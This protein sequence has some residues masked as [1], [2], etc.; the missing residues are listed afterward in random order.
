MK[1][2][3]QH[4]E[5]AKLFLEFN[6]S[7]AIYAEMGLGKTAIVLSY[8]ADHMR[9]GE[10][11]DVLVVCPASLVPNWEQAI[12]E[13]ADFE[14]ITEDDLN[15]LRKITIRSYQKM[16][17]SSKVD[18]PHRDGRVTKKRSL[19]LREDV[20]RKWDLFV[21]DESHS[22]GT[23]NSIQTKSAISLSK[24]SDRIILLSGTPFHGPGGRPAYAKMYGQFQVLS[25]G[26]LWRSWTQFCEEYVTSYDLWHNP[27][28]FN[29]EKCRA[30]I[31]DHSIT[32]R[33]ADCVD[34][35]ERVEQTI[36]CPL[37]ETKMYEDI[38]KGDVSKYGIDIESG[39][40]FYLKMLQICSGSMKRPTDT[41][42]L[43]TSKDDVLADILN[44]TDDKVVVFCNYRASVDRCAQI[45]RKAG[46]KTIT[47]DGR[48]ASDAWKQFTEGDCTAIVCQYQSGGVGLNL[49]CSHTMVLFEPCLSAL[50]LEQAKGRIYRK[51]Q[52]NRCVYYY[53]TTPKSIE[54]RVADSVRKG[55][56]VSNEM[57]ERFALEV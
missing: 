39:G 48:S 45:C 42:M 28:S 37:A 8:V 7:L 26:K 1:R 4:Q 22:I 14:G 44:G 13:M 47:Y 24:L 20:D 16:Y 55:V 34:M 46:R 6:P 29:E 23:H 54:S 32:Y 41:M 53:L 52:A 2:L 56:D 27:R 10:I 50:L 30:V 3:M 33:L 9:T 38:K 25:K 21:V 18:V 12:E 19:S 36:P 40:G 31:K 51:G 15:N 35:P 11:K 17:S 5:E 57:L 49:Q 43:R